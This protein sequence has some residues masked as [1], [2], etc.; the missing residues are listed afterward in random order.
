MKKYLLSLVLACLPFSPAFSAPLPPMPEA[1]ALWVECE[2]SQETMSSRKKIDDLVAR[3]K[4]GG[5]NVLFVQVYRHDRAW[6]NSSY[7]DATPYRLALKKEKIDPLAYVLT[8]AHQEGLEVHAWVNVFRIGKN[9]QTP[10]LRRL[11]KSALTADGKGRSIL[12]YHP[13][14]L[15]DGGYWLEPADKSVRSH[16]C[17]L[18]EELLR[19]YP[20]LDGL[21]LD[22]IRYPYSSPT[23]GSL[24]AQRKDFGYGKAAVERY[25]AE[26]GVNPLTMEL[27]RASCQKWDDWRRRQVTDTVMDIAAT[28]KKVKPALK[29]SADAVAYLDRA[30]LSAFQDW[31][32]WL[33]TGLVDFIAVMNYS[34]DSRLARYLTRASTAARGRRQVYIGLGAYLLLDRP[35]A[36][37]DQIEDCRSAGANGIA[38]FSYDAMLTAPRIFELV[39]TRAFRR[40]AV[41]PAMKWK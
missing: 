28:V 5:F 2:G 31:R 41:V 34:T 11:G 36:L 3:A 22:F 9:L 17:R 20:S 6:F 37:V 30:Y 7:A 15:P 40:P 1:R 12:R 14:D 26:T 33:E 38:L 13:A 4:A 32:S 24:W 29:F 23:A 27:T 16:L 21:Q 39:R 18:I 19:R 10:V 8:R 35:E 25:K